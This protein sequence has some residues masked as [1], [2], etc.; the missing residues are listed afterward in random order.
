MKK[1]MKCGAMQ[2]DNA[3]FCNMCGSKF[4]SNTVNTVNTENII[5][6]T[7]RMSDSEFMKKKSIA[8]QKNARLFFTIFL[9]IYI[10]TLLIEF[11]LS[12]MGSVINGNSGSFSDVA[13][14]NMVGLV[15]LM[16]ASF[17]WGLLPFFASLAYAIKE[18][19]SSLIFTEI[20]LLAIH[21]IFFFT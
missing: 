20:I 10:G 13:G 1:C 21:F 17:F 16:A 18:K 6:T 19:M 2:E 8:N 14:P 7:S 5:Q 12:Q 4:E 11:R 3:V 15:R 9:F